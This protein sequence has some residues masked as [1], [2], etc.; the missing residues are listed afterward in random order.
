MPTHHDRPRPMPV[1]M[2]ISTD[3][4]QCKPEQRLG[5]DDLVATIR[6]KT[7]SA[8]SFCISF[9]MPA[10]SLYSHTLSLFLLGK[11]T[12]LGYARI[13]GS[14]H[15]FTSKEGWLLWVY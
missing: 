2:R 9:S 8:V 14:T 7:G 6:I 12:L 15:T 4:I 1:D 10:R 3:F 5:T 13:D 11:W